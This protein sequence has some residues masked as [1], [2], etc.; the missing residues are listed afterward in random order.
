MSGTQ[1]RSTVYLVLAAIGLVGTAY[2]NVQWLDGDGDH[3]IRSFTEAGFAN[4]A[5]SSASTDLLVG[6]TAASIFIVV[7]GLRVGMRHAWVYVA[8]SMIT[9]F[10][11]AFP[12]FLWQR[13]R[14]LARVASA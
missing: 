5:S 7:E 11:F 4:S 14:H 6:F 2:F 9:A 12:L 8:V 3:T 1:V 13:E 10:A